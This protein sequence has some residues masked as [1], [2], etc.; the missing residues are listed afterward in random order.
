[1]G[2]TLRRVRLHSD[3]PDSLGANDA[4][5]PA[6]M[7]GRLLE[8]AHLAGYTFERACT[9]LEWLLQEDRWRK[10]GGGFADINA[11]LASVRFDDLRVLAEPRK[12]LVRRIKALQPDAQN[13]KIAK[14]LGV[15]E[16]TVRRDASTNVERGQEKTNA[17]S[18][19]NVGGSTNVELRTRCEIVESGETGAG[20]CGCVKVTR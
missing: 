11:F 14:A 9:N 19:P 2:N 20:D 3:P 1:M 12:R 18:R 8:G 10:V 16:I 17:A 7:Y 13:T 5:R 15:S 6:E 4:D